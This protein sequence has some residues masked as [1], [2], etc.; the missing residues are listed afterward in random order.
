[1]LSTYKVIRAVAEAESAAHFDALTANGG[2]FLAL[3]PFGWSAGPVLQP[4]E[5]PVP[6]RQTW[7]VAEGDLWGFLSLLKALDHGAFHEAAG[8]FGLEVAD[9]WA[10]DG[11][12]LLIPSRG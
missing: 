10:G 12:A 7:P 2:G 3:G 4:H 8:R 6:P 11:R 9:D 1:A 5:L